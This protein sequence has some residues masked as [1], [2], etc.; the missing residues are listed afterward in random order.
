[1]M[2][3]TE[4]LWLNAHSWLIILLAVTIKC[5]RISMYMLEG[6]FIGY[7]FCTKKHCKATSPKIVVTSQ[8]P[9][10][11][12]LIIITYHLI[13]MYPH[14]TL[15]WKTIHLWRICPAINLHWI[16]WISQ[17]A[18]F[19]YSELYGDILNRCFHKW[20]PPSYACWFITPHELCQYIY[21]Q[22]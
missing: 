14:Q 4:F 22:P 9:M 15:Q 16:F 7:F 3:L 1:M 18:T 19:W 11:I 2:E 21:H 17:P 20:S 5:S 10:L 6:P 12:A 8:Y 13:M